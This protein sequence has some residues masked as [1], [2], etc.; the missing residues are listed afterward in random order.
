ML[1]PILAVGLLIMVVGIFAE[2]AKNEKKKPV[3][4]PVIHVVK[5]E[6]PKPV[7]KPKESKPPADNEPVE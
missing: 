4:K 6:P 5:S 3:K 2:A 7:V 1:N